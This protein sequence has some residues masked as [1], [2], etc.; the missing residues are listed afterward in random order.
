VESS[1]ADKEK[2]PAAKLVL[3]YQRTTNISPTITL[4]FHILEK[5]SKQFGD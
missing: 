3:S 5:A 2:N 4:S 1:A